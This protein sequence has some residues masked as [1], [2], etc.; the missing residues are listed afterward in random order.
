MPSHSP[1]AELELT[2]LVL[3]RERDLNRVL[4]QVKAIG[5]LTVLVLDREAFT[6]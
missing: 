1:G 4:K 2:L 5:K 3:D 6:R